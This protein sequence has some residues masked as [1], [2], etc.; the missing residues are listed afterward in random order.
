MSPKRQVDLLCEASKC[1][2]LHNFIAV[3]LS[4]INQS[5]L[6]NLFTRCCFMGVC[7]SSVALNNLYHCSCVSLTLS[8]LSKI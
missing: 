5:G 1:K 2:R 7:L 6:T 8:K 3:F 4:P